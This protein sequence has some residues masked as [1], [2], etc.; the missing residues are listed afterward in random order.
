MAQDFIG[1]IHAGSNLSNGLTESN[2]PIKLHTLGEAFDAEIMR[3]KQLLET[4]CI[5]KA[6]ADT[7][8]LLQAP[9]TD[10]RKILGHVI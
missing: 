5:S 9:V 2:Q 3:T 10:L 7:L 6:K 8:G 1:L 4:L